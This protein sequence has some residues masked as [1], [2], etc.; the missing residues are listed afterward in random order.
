MFIL[1][2]LL[3]GATTVPKLTGSNLGSSTKKCSST[4]HWS[5]SSVLQKNVIKRYS[6]TCIKGFISREKRKWS[7]KTGGL[8]I[9]PFTGS[10][11]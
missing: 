8:S 10:V 7:L 11:I 5:E 4:V 1:K 3:A 6:K 9:Q 2:V